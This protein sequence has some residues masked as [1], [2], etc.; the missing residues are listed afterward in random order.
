MKKLERYDKDILLADMLNLSLASACKKYKDWALH[1]MGAYDFGLLTVVVAAREVVWPLYAAELKAKKQKKEWGPPPFESVEQIWEELR[2]MERKTTPDFLER[3]QKAYPTL[4]AG[5]YAKLRRCFSYGMS[6]ELREFAVKHHACGYS[7]AQVIDL[8]LSD[9]ALGEKLTPFFV[10]TEML[11]GITQVFRDYLSTKL[12]YLKRGNPRWPAKYDDLWDAERAKH[13]DSIKGIPLTH[14]TEQISAMSEHYLKLRDEFDALP[15][16]RE[17]TRDRGILTR[18][19]VQ[20]MS[21]LFA[22]T[23]DPAAI[24]ANKPALQ[25]EAAMK[26]V[27]KQNT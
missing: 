17:S 1:E 13:L 3:S 9:E 18:A 14:I 10:Y 22:L 23:R 6:Q 11:K 15:P 21:G 2:R 26:A 7:T 5:I 12:N 24:P 16:G 19:M 25:G 20:T 27:T 4:E 8:L